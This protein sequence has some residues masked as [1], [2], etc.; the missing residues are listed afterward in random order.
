MVEVVR[1]KSI[2]NVFSTFQD[3]IRF[4]LLLRVPDTEIRKLKR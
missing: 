1:L 4:F 2:N 3:D